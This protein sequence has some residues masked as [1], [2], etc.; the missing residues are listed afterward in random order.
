MLQNNELFPYLASSDNSHII[1][2]VGFSQ[3]LQNN[4]RAF[5]TVILLRKYVPAIKYELRSKFMN[6]ILRELLMCK[7]FHKRIQVPKTK[8]A[9]T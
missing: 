5:P 3:I 4:A 7:M 1:L 6:E 2:A 9:T 8:K